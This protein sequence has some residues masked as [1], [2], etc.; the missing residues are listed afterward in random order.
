MNAIIIGA[1]S[2]I[3]KNL[4]ARLANDGWEIYPYNRMGCDVSDSIAIDSFETPDEWDLLLV[5]A[6]TLSPIGKFVSI[7]AD[8]WEENVMVNALGPLRLL[9]HLLPHR[10]PNAAAVFFSGTNPLKVNPLYSA[11]SASKALLARAVQ[12]IDSEID[13]K[14]FLLAPGFVQ[15]KIHAVHDVSTRTDGTTHDQIYD[16]LKH[17]LSRP[18]A[19]VG[20]KIIHVPTWYQTWKVMN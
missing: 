8:E 9:R 2:D 10:K 14:C 1:N 19:E 17:C 13:A 16:C 4:S 11:Y 18:K 6:G 20:G 12:E 5:A 7:P 3:A 15:T